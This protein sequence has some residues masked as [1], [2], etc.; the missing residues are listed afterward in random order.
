MTRQYIIVILLIVFGQSVGQGQTTKLQSSRYGI[1]LIYGTKGYD[2]RLVIDYTRFED[3]ID[4]NVDIL[5]FDNVG[6]T[7]GGDGPLI[8]SSKEPVWVDSLGLTP[9][10]LQADS[11][12]SL[13]SLIEILDTKTHVKLGDKFEFRITYRVDGKINQ[14]F[15]KDAK[16]S[17]EFF[18][19]IEK[20]IIKMNNKEAL[21]KYYHFLWPSMLLKRPDLPYITHSPRGPVEW[22]Y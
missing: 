4:N 17:T 15:V 5:R 8:I 1:D 22:E 2:K 13:I 9:L 18:K 19:A 14:Y 12:K 21:D 6:Y 11:L 3:G 10:K 16:L 7:F 20:R